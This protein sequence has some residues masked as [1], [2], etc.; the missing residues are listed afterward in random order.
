MSNISLLLLSLCLASMYIIFALSL[1]SNLAYNSSYA[2]SLAID[3]AIL[4]ALLASMYA[5]CCSSVLSFCYALNVSSLAVMARRVSSFPHRLS[6]SLY[7]PFPLVRPNVS[8]AVDLS[9]ISTI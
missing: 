4:A 1:V 3:Q 8:L 9:S 2:S 6:F 7:A 5:Q